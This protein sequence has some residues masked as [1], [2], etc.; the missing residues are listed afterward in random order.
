MRYLGVL[1]IVKP[2]FMYIMNTVAALLRSMS[3]M[4]IVVMDSNTTVGIMTARRGLDT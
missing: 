1:I 2:M 3:H 4:F